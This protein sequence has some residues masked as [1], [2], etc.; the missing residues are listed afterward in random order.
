MSKSLNKTKAKIKLTIEF[1]T[2]AAI[3]QARKTPATSS[4]TM[5]LSS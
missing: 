2:L 4:I 1:S 3:A 5:C